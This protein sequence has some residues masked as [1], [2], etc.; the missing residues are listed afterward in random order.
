MSEIAKPNKTTQL[1]LS[2]IS[3]A[4][5]EWGNPN[6]I[7]LVALHG[8]LD[9][10]AS[11]YPLI[12]D[13]KWLDELD[14]RFI[15]VDM[16]GHGYSSHRSADYGYPFYEYVVD[17]HDLIFALDLDKHILLGHSMGGGIATIYSGTE[18]ADNLGLILIES[19]GP[20]THEAENAPQQLLK[21]L[22]YRKQSKEKPPNKTYQSIK[23]IVEMRASHSDI[24]YQAAELILARNMKET[25]DGFVWRSDPR[26][27]MPSTM[28]L[29]AEQVN[30]FIHNIQC[31][32]QL[33]Y[34]EDGPIKN[35]PVIEGRVEL[36]NDVEVCALQGG[37]HLH[38]TEPESVRKNIIKF[39]KNRILA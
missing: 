17:L 24:S 33:L 20:L 34:A 37:H 22:N 28:Y 10:M 2:D 29:S 5:S 4:I 31:P 23:P 25:N 21:H 14:L 39:I 9:N 38:M 13:G 12:G 35:Y 16:A 8:W 26:L 36:L 7:A 3:L 18:V 15:A 30:A 32:T 6:G 1:K 19:L 11:F 27:N